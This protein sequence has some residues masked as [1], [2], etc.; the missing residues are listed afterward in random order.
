MEEPT[1]P[2]ISLSSG[3]LYACQCA[4]WMDGRAKGK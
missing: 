2:V 4:V 1:L 3:R